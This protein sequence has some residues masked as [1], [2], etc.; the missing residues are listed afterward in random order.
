MERINDFLRQLVETGG[1]FGT[2]EVL[3][4]LLDDYG[5]TP[6]VPTDAMRAY[7]L[8]ASWKNERTMRRRLALWAQTELDRRLQHAT[9]ARTSADTF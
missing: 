1:D 4:D 6:P 7:R 9:A 3:A 8:A 2:L 5:L